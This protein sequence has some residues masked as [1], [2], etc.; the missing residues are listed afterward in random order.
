MSRGGGEIFT[1]QVVVLLALR[2]RE[3]VQLPEQQGV[4]EDPLDGLDQV[5]L[6]RG[7]ML[8]PRVPQGQEGLEV[9]IRLS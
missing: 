3:G 4:L 6:Q 5:G 2:V 1:V 9:R 7:R 8:L